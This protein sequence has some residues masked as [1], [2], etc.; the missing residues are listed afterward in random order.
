MR[1]ENV[2]LLVTKPVAVRSTSA[3]RG[4]GPGVSRW[5]GATGG[6]W[7]DGCADAMRDAP[8]RRKVC[9][10]EGGSVALA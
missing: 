10:R 7:R 4:A 3:D 2:S 1:Q 8:D 9:G 6:G 5:P